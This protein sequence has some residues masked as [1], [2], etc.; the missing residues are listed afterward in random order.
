MRMHMDDSE[1]RTLQVDISGAPKRLQFKARG[2]LRRRVGPILE[3]AMKKDAAGHMGNWF[4]R[5]GT[6]YVTPLPPHVSNE[7]VGPWTVEAGIESK[8]AGKLAHIIAYGSVNNAPAYDPMSG[9]RRALPQIEH[10]L[11]NDV[12]DAVLGGE[13]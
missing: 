7:M 3:R 6:E 2:T 8:G 5:P 9:P 4:G 10:L 1:L 13:K 12:E 11:A